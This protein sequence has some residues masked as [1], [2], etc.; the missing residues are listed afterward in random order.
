MRSRLGELFPDIREPGR[1]RL[2]NSL[3]LFLSI[4]LFQSSFAAQPK[5][6]QANGAMVLR[7]REISGT[8]AALQINLE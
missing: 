1:G 8:G 4:S 6:F 3:Y 2:S 5:G 7:D